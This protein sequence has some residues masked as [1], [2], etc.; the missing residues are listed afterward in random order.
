MNDLLTIICGDALTELRKLPDESVQC[1][2]TSPPYFNL[3]D[4]GIEGQLGC[5]KRPAD[6][7]ARLVQIFQE[8]KRVLAADGVAWLNIGDS[9][10]NA[11]GKAL[12]PGG[13]VGPNA[14]LHSTHKDAG[15]VPLRRPNKSDLKH[16]WFGCKS[17]DLLLIPFR[18]AIALQE[19][20]WYVRDDIVWDKA[21]CMPESTTDRC[22]RSHEF[23]FHLT[24]SANYFFDQ[25]AIKEPASESDW[26]SRIGR[27]NL[28]NKLLPTDELNGIRPRVKYTPNGKKQDGHGR[29]HDGFNARW[30]EM[31]KAKLTHG[32]DRR[33]G[34]SGAF[35]NN[36]AD[37]PVNGMRNKRDVWTVAP[38]NYPEAHFATYPPDLIKPCILAGSRPGDTI[39]DPFAGSGTTGMVALEL[40]RKAILIELNPQ[41]CELIKQRC[42]VTPGLGI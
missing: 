38:A 22:T 17:K 13:R 24:K 41:Y 3:R 33:R 10:C 9:Y 16:G 4:Y 31:E 34:E 39:L 11:Q 7:V 20:G 14:C 2:V 1:C 26:E 40:G 18:V 12:N 5:E 32:Q 29:R 6:Y 8:I 42:H 30:D 35:S 19:D 36:K 23:I 21:N 27:A 15:V 37:R 25:E 28:N